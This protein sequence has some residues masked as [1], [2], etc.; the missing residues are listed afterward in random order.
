M[1][2]WIMQA[3]SKKPNHFPK[4]LNNCSFDGKEIEVGWEEK[5]ES[6]LIEKA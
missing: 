1:L 4:E 3:T 5:K 6:R 2:Y